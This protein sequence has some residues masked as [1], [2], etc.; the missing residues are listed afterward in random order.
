MAAYTDLWQLVKLR[1]ATTADLLAQK[2]HHSAPRKRL[3]L[4]CHFEEILLPGIR[5]LWAPARQGNERRLASPLASFLPSCLAK[6]GT[7]SL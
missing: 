4:R 5:C 2:P 7:Q 3:I 6:L 1:T